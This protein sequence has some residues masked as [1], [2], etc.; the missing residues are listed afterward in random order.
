MVTMVDWHDLVGEPTQMSI[1]PKSSYYDPTI[2]IENPGAVLCLGLRERVHQYVVPVSWRGANRETGTLP[3]F[4]TS[5]S[6]GPTI[7][8]AK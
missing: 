1:D 2:G 3:Q 5:R 6:S 7:G 8:P 4:Q